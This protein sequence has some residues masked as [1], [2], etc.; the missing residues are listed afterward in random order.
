VSQTKQNKQN[1]KT[2]KEKKKI[3]SLGRLISI[4]DFQAERGASKKNP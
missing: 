4:S 3:L 2:N 1:E